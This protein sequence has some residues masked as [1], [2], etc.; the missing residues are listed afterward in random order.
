MDGLRID[1]LWHLKQNRWLPCEQEM[2]VELRIASRVDK[3]TRLIT[4]A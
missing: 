3:Q 2:Y 1:W 4:C